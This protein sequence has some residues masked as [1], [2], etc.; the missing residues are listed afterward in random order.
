MLEL[1]L[2]DV[3]VCAA[4]IMVAALVVIR[5]WRRRSGQPS[6]PASRRGAAAEPAGEVMAPREIAIV[7]GFADT[8]QPDPG[9][10]V[11]APPGQAAHLQARPAAGPQGPG[12]QP[13]GQQATATAVTTSERIAGYY[14]QADKPMAD[15]LTAL[16][17]TQPPRGPESP[18]S[19]ERARAPGSRRP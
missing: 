13:N 9:A 12:P 18:G 3:A 7:P 2:I 6:M 5:R 16:G 11:P 17:W 15:Y 4:L 14:D 10:H 8:V 19:A 1:L